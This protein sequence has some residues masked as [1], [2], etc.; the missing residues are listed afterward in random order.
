[1]FWSKYSL[2]IM[3]KQSD[4]FSSYITS[5]TINLFSSVDIP[6]VFSLSELN[7]RSMARVGLVFYVTFLGC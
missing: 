6:S 3:L 1:M 5:V 4:S 2:T 7:L